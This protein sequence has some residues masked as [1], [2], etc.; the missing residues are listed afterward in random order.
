MVLYIVVYYSFGDG[1]AYPT[2]TVDISSDSLLADR[3]RWMEEGDADG[4]K[5]EEGGGEV[6]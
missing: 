2:R 4:G 3:Q 1:I 5:I 6:L